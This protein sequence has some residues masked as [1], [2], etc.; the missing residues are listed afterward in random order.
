MNEKP[1]MIDRG[2]VG[3]RPSLNI[4]RQENGTQQYS[5]QNQLQQRSRIQQ[6]PCFGMQHHQKQNQLHHF[7]HKQQKLMQQPQ[8]HQQQK[9]QHQLPDNK[10]AQHQQLLNYHQ[11]QLQN[12]HQ[13]QPQSLTPTTNLGSNNATNQSY[14]AKAP[15]FK[16][17]TN[18]KRNFESGINSF[19][20]PNGGQI[21]TG[22]SNGTNTPSQNQEALHQLRNN[23]SIVLNQQQSQQKLLNAQNGS[24]P[25]SLAF[26]SKS[27]QAYPIL[28]NNSTAPSLAEEK[29]GAGNT[30][31]SSNSNA[32]KQR[33]NQH[34]LAPQQ[35][36]PQPL[37]MPT[38]LSPR[39]TSG[40]FALGD[41]F[42]PL[43]SNG[44]AKDINSLP[45]SSSQKNNSAVGN[46]SEETASQAVANDILMNNLFHAELN[47][48]RETKRNGK[49]NV[50]KSSPNNVLNAS[51]QSSFQLPSTMDKKEMEVRYQ[52]VA[53]L[54]LKFDQRSILLY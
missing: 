44:I 4:N 28:S 49:R 30:D 3:I 47:S 5:H 15:N 46:W 41:E 35:F 40:L 12:Y 6:T 23:L 14:L 9:N 7:D 52:I 18:P 27:H 8:R 22:T 21:A 43:S 25:S 51:Q 17:Q 38:T 33:N 2:V 19:P 1:W 31:D 54:F 10:K 29:I 32:S 13:M 26:Q 34:Q 50:P 16:S 24:G 39:S 36:R 37:S 45:K 20:Y 48:S 42:Q 11:S 53:Y